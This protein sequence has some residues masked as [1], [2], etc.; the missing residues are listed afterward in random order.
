MLRLLA[1]SGILESTLDRI[2]KR[3]MEE[4]G[5]NVDDD[6]NLLDGDE[7]AFAELMHMSRLQCVCVLAPRKGTLYLGCTASLVNP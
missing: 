5:H 1:S 3:T 4:D 7:L 2:Q 6:D